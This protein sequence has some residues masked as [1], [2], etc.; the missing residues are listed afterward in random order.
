MEEKVL[1]EYWRSTIED[2]ED[3]LKLVKKGTVK[4]VGVSAGKRPIYK[5]EYGKSNVKL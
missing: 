4:Q 3:T 1:P 5:I 2:L